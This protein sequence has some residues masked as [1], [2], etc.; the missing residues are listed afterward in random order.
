MGLMIRGGLL[1]NAK[2]HIRGLLA[3]PKPLACWSS[4]LMPGKVAPAQPRLQRRAERGRS[5][6]VLAM[7]AM[8]GRKASCA[9]LRVAPVLAPRRFEPARDPA[10]PLL[11]SNRLKQREQP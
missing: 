4:I 6:P 8:L 10:F 7:L 1:P 2:Q 5:A 11:I 3:L 9:W